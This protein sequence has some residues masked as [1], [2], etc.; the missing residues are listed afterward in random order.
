LF[1]SASAT[2]AK[3]S[4]V[5]GSALLCPPAVLTR[6][7]LHPG[8]VVA[9]TVSLAVISVALPPGAKVALKP[10]MSAVTAPTSRRLAA[11]ELDLDVL[12][13][14]PGGRDQSLQDGG[15]GFQG[16]GWAW[17]L[18]VASASRTRAPS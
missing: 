6:K 16:S 13:A 9:G 2:G 14:R 18:P 12:A 1:G 17:T 8:R 11:D 4:T 15:F 3:A 5:K 10:G 7:E